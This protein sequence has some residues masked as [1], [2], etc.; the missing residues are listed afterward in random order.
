MRGALLTRPLT[1]YLTT[2]IIVNYDVCTEQPKCKKL[3]FLG[4]PLLI[5]QFELSRSVPQDQF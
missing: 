5:A 1:H 3:P 4:A 2:Y